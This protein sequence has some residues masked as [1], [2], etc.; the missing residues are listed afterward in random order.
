MRWILIISVM[1]FLTGCHPA[2]YASSVST[3]AYASYFEIQDSVIKVISPYDASVDI[4]SVSEPMDRIICMSSSNVAALSIIGCADAISAVSGLRYISDKALHDRAVPDIGYEN[5]MDY[6]TVLSL[7]PD[8]LVAYTVSGTEPQY[9]SKLRS[10]GIRVL[11]I[12]DH[13]EQHPLARAEYVRLFG[14]LTGRLAAADSVF[15]AVCNRYE[16][17][18]ASVNVKEP[19]KVLMNIPYGDAWY[20]PGADSYMS[21]IIRDAGGEVLGSEPG[22]S[23]SK[24]ISMEQA[25][26]LSLDADM[27]LNPGHCRSIGDLTSFHHFFDRFGPVAKGL[28]V[29]NNTSRTTESGGNDFWETG[30]VRPDLILEDLVSIFSESPSDSLNYFFRLDQ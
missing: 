6:E 3:S 18:A 27:W 11:V 13:L 30:A 1:F 17:L 20:I 23:R 25:Y 10:L 4:L 26:A 19:V 5:S 12:H 15:N 24:V 8:I 22:T 21:H 7:D 2:R 28:P 29:Y 16:Q 9:L 14:V